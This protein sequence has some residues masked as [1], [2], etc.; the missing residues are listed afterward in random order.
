MP[1]TLL[2]FAFFAALV[3]GQVCDLQFDARVPNDL[4]VA[5]F[6]GVNDVFSNTFVVGEGLQF[7]QVVQLPNV[8]QALVRPLPLPTLSPQMVILTETPSSTSKP[9]SPSK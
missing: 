8:D 1:S 7:S 2:P 3:A 5:G 6:D 4:G 9:R